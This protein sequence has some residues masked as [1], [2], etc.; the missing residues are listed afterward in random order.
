LEVRLHESS[1]ALWILQSSN[2]RVTTSHQASFIQAPTT[3]AD[4]HWPMTL[5]MKDKTRD[6][7][8]ADRKLTVQVQIESSLGRLEVRLHE[9]S[10]ALWILPSSNRRATTSHKAS[11]IEA[12]MKRANKHWPITLDMQIESSLDRDTHHERQNSRPRRCKKLTVQVQIESSLGRL[13]VRLHESS[14]WILPSSNRRATT[15]HQ[16]SFIHAPTTRPNKHWPMTPPPL[17]RGFRAPFSL[18]LSRYES[19]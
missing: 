3:R 8:G 9:S 15:S 11:L 10:S 14:L 17:G 4:K 5:I 6:R 13:E 18:P 19:S 12:L 1:S 7:A 16:A 2:R